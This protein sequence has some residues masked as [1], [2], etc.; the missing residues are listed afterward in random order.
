MV[1]PPDPLALDAATLSVHQ[2]ATFVVAPHS[3]VEALGASPLFTLVEDSGVARA[4][5]MGFSVDES[6]AFPLGRI[7]VHPQGILLDAFSEERVRELTRRVDSL[8]SWRVTPDETRAIRFEDAVAEPE[9]LMHPLAE[10]EG[11]NP[12]ARDLGAWYLRAAWPFLPCDGLRGRTPQIAA[13]TGRGRDAVIKLLA[14]LG[15]DLREVIPGFPLFDF[16]EIRDLLFPEPTPAPHAP[17]KRD[18]TR[19]V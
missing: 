13:Q 4:E 18:A 8:G 15:L 12:S 1:R 17:A 14:D 16:E 10:S 19:R 6:L 7:T 9:R 11:R 2:I 5:W 3:L